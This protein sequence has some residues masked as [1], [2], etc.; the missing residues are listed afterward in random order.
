M[1][2]NAQPART[3]AI[4]DSLKVGLG[5]LVATA[6]P[7]D[8]L[9]ALGLGSCIGLVMADP[10][11]RVAGMAHVMLPESNISG[12][13]TPLQEGKYADTAVPALLAAV[14]R[15]GADRRRLIV[16][17]AGGAQMFNNGSGAGV[18]NIGTRNAI[19][20]RE[21]LAVAGLKLNAAQTGGSSGRTMDVVV[22]TGIVTV[23][24]V[25]G[26]PQEI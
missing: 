26:P 6:N 1:S 2:T 10:Q 22:R 16:K 9:V 24:V 8:T 12:A 4:A 11:A 21:A 23:R 25:G 19:A 3:R 13:G 17:M 20:V 5:A 18:L 14:L 7:N 15:L